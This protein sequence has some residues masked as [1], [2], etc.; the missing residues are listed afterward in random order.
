MPTHSDNI[1]AIRRR[2]G[3]PTADAPSDP[4]LMQLLIDQAANFTASLANTRNHW[5]VDHVALTVNEGQEDYLIAAGSFGR[6][7]LVYT[8]D[9]TDTYHV[10][11]EIPIVLMQD[12]DQRYLGAQQAGTGGVNEHSAAEVVFYRQYQ[13]WYARFVPI[14]GGTAT[15]QIWY[16]ATYEYGSPSDDVGLSAFHHLLRVQA[17]I[18]ALPH[19]AWRDVSV[20]SNPKAW[21]MKVKA[22]RDSLVYD[23]Q[24]F[25]KE[26]KSYRA[27]SSREGVSSKL[28]YAPGFD[29]A[30]GGGSMANGWGW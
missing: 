1:A 26:F 7:F 28:G 13:N 20:M 8:T 14:P 4:L 5:S 27:Q 15:Y 29:D 3:M 9:E 24:K 25:E 10:R 21:E 17:A 18:S 23:E 11:R 30:G 16:E 19:C 12:A 22:L 2:L 6:P